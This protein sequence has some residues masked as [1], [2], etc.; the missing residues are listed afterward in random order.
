MPRITKK[1]KVERMKELE[2]KI[3][4]II[5]QCMDMGVNES[6]NIIDLNSGI[7][8]KYNGK[9]NLNKFLKWGD[10]PFRR[11]EMKFDPINDYQLAVNLYE[12]F[13]ERYIREYIAEE[14]EEPLIAK[15]RVISIK[16]GNLFNGKPTKYLD[17]TLP[18]DV[19]GTM[20]T[21]AYIF[22]S[23]AYL[24]MIINQSGLGLAV[25]NM[26]LELDGL[27]GELEWSG[28]KNK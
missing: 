6:N 28:T 7:F 22:P 24:E 14:G 10:G 4:V 25:N 13:I 26:L 12:L 3:N 8:V 23:L 15:V 16:D 21:Q 19:K 2:T 18:S 20:R 27:K 11:R 9:N 17:F 5:L 1:M